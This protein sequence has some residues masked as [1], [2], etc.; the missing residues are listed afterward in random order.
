M[1]GCAVF[2]GGVGMD[3]RKF[4][5][6]GLGLAGSALISSRAADLATRLPADVGPEES[7]G[8][9]TAQFPDGFLWGMATASY[10]VEGAW[11][12]DGKG[13]SIWDRYAHAQGHIKGSDTGD[14]ACDH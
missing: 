14:V 1:L 3:R 10:Q 4:I 9:V 13:E 6:S 5:G 11:N 8:G 7:Q 2:E 12:E